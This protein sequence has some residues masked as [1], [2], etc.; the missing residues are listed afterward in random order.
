MVTLLPGEETGKD[1]EMAELHHEIGDAMLEDYEHHHQQE[2]RRRSLTDD[3]IEAIAD[4]VIRRQPHA[5]RFSDVDHDDLKASL[6]F[7]KTIEELMSETG[8]TVRK[9]LIVAGIGGLVSLLIIGL[10][11]KIKQEL[12]V[13]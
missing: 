11:A 3:D 4:A 5:C 6:R 12:G 8:S 1:G 10:Y 7:H 9:T 13:H 2:R